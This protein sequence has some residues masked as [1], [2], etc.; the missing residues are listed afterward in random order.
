MMKRLIFLTLSALAACGTPQEQCIG[1]NTRDLRT[2]DRLIAETQGNL[3]RGYAFETIT[4]YED[5]WTT[6][7]PPS[8]AEGE[9]PPPPRMCLDERPV[10]TER[11]KAID[12]NAEARKLDSLKA[13]R[14]ELARQAE[15]VIAQCKAE[16]PE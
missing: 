8:V 3:D 12:L 10:T 16:F 13:K 11:P 4:V 6:C 2:V 5:Y 14:R 7:P 1:R 15:V 9:T